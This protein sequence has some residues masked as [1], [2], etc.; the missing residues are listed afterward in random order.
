M[1]DPVRVGVLGAGMISEYHVGGLKAAGAE[2]VSICGLDKAAE[3]AARHGI[4]QWTTDYRVVLARQ[5]V[6][7]VVIA[8]PDFTHEEIAVAAARAGK[9]ILLQKPMARSSAECGRIIEAAEKAGV[10][11]CVSFMH[12]YFDEVIQARTL[13][14]E[15]ALGTVLTVRQR[16]ATPGPDWAAWFFSKENVGG[17]AVL[18]LGVHGIDLV[19]HL[20]GEIEA[21]MA[22]TATMRKERVL[23]DGTVVHPDNDDTACAFYRLVTGALVVHEISLC[24]AAGTDRFRTEVYGEAG[25]LWLRSE[26]GLLAI[27]APAHTGQDGWVCPHLPEEPLGKQHHAHWLAMVRGEEEPDD[28]AQAGLSTNLVA[29]AIYR[30]AQS[31][32]WEKP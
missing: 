19:R 32:R 5:D 15:R 3:V 1:K 27:H 24:E 16:N 25:T 6:E 22:V 29:E 7:A 2:L 9:A 31:G 28:S 8:T 23:A 30:S 12:R 4:P 10:L 13:L 14:G 17:G 26:R 21:V 18:Q 11:L 20:F